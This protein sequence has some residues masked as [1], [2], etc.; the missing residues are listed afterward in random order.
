MHIWIVEMFINETDRW[1][2]TVGCG[3][4]RGD[5]RK[6]KQRWEIRNPDNKFRVMKYRR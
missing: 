4:T 5:A 1:E 2:P 6:E 3:L